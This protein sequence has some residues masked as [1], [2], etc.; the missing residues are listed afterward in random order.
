MSYCPRSSRSD[1]TI[2][3]ATQPI[4]VSKPTIKLMSV[5]KLPRYLPA[6]CSD[7]LD[8]GISS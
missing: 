2:I 5:G 8:V 3:L 1:Y 7:I 4:L 6:S